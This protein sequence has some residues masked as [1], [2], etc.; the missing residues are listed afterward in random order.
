MISE[1]LLR[2]LLLVIISLPSIVNAQTTKRAVGA[3][4]DLA[5]KYID[6]EIEIETARKKAEI[7]VE[8]FRQ[9]QQAQR[10]STNA[11]STSKGSENLQEKLLAARH[12]QWAQIVSSTAFHSWLTTKPPSFSQLCLATQE[13]LT[14]AHCIDEFFGPPVP[15]SKPK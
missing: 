15:P 1:N 11:R 10:A 9:L 2:A 4:S 14:L 3:M 7:E 13:G 8:K 6:Q 12:P 5:N